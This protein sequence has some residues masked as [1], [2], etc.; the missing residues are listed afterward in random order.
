M[1]FTEKAKEEEEK[2]KE[3]ENEK[4]EIEKAREER[5][6]KRYLAKEQEVL[7]LERETEG[8]RYTLWNMI[9][10]GNPILNFLFVDSILFPRHARWTLLFINI[11]L[12]W[13][14]CAIIYNNTKSP[15][16]VPDFSKRASKLAS[17]ELWISLIA[18]VGNMLLMYL[19]FALFRISDQR[20][21]FATN[22]ASL[23]EM[24]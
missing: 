20:T 10:Y 16:D 22:L 19:F 8:D 7:R 11:M 4:R 6:N 2:A 23:K 17:Q 18:P 14:F 12:I 21:K 13:F 5:E 24:L 15:L 9:K 3:M 1:V